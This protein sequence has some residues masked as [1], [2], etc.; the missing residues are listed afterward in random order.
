MA[1]AELNTEY[2]TNIEAVHYRG[3]APMWADVASQSIEGGI[4]SYVAALPVLQA[5]RGKVVGA[6]GRSISMAPDVK[7]FKEQ[8]ATSKLFTLRGFSGV[9]SAPAGT[10]MEIVKKLSDLMVAAGKDEKTQ[11]ALSNFAIDKPVGYEETQTIYKEEA[12]L[13]LKFLSALNLTPQ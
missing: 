9:L 8:G 13:T 1:I 7:T 2:G 5:G 4:G 12:P 10:S 3:E 11:T 6:I